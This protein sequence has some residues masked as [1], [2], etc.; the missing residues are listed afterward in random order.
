M[1]YPAA[2][3]VLL[4]AVDFFIANYNLNKK[5]LTVALIILIGGF[6]ISVIWNWNHGQK[7][8][9]QFKLR[10]LITYFIIAA[11][12]LVLSTYYW[13]TSDE[14]TRNHAAIDMEFHD[15]LAVLPFE[16]ESKDPELIYLSDGIP[17][18]LIN[19]LSSL[20]DLKVLSRNSTFI[21][22]SSDR[23][24]KG[25][26]KKLKADLMLTG[27]IEKL[28]NDLMVNCQLIDVSEDVQI[29]GDKIHYNN[30]DVIKVEEAIVSSLLKT[31]ESKLKSKDAKI[32]TSE[33]SNPKALYNYMKG[34]ALSYGSTH[35]EAEKALSYFREAITIDP[36][37]AKAYVGIANEK[38]IQAIF[39]TASRETIFNEART[40]V[41]TALAFDPNSSE[42]LYLNG[43]IKFYGDFD[44]QG[45]EEA[46]KKS[47]EINPADADALVRYSAYLVA[48]KRYE[49]AIDLA[50]QAIELDPISISGLHNLGWVHLV[51]GNFIKSEMAFSEALEIHPNWIWGYVKRGYAKMFQNNY[52]EAIK[53]AQKARQLMGD[54]GSELL[55]AATIYILAYSGE[56]VLAAKYTNNF[57]SNVSTINYQDPFAVS[58]VYYA[59]NNIEK[60]LEWAEICYNDKAPGAYQYNI[61]IFYQDDVLNHP[62]F[63]ELRRK[64]NF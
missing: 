39:S 24:P 41:Q 19:R 7:G 17:E 8:V 49:E 37:Y 1:A 15:I 25:V 13:Q 50:N 62:E 11:A 61:D 2:A 59:N 23:N 34:R 27:R 52:Q 38:I 53:D 46:Y 33:T 47:I 18:N 3:F 21:L 63:I 40:A 20:T 48:M 57:L 51:S 12:S 45:A 5:F 26:S 4:Q 6:F 22:E 58:I 9:Q 54:S 55:E 64:M 16:N 10:E 43:A 42:A 44:W 32:N 30:E 31:L 36:T 29:W 28:E 14:F 60:M 56:D 35:E